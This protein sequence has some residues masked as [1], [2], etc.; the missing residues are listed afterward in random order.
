IKIAAP[1]VPD[2][3]QGC[4]VW[5]LSLVDPDNRRSVDWE[6]R[7]AFLAALERRIAEDRV[8]LAREVGKELVDGRA[9]LL[10][11]REGLAL[12]KRAPELFPDG[13]YLPLPV[14]GAHAS[15]T[16]AFA[17]R[18]GAATVVC[19]VPRLVLALGGDDPSAIAW[20]GRVH[21][22]RDI[23]RRL[24]C[25]VSGLEVRPRSGG[26]ALGE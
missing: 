25:A 15:N 9:K 21:L 10:L 11:I 5:D 18:R 26:L 13:S 1:G 4:E 8:A 22:P 20:E 12:R 2:I 14:E 16:F 3:Y 17:R 19:V 6:R 7:E 23:G 24:V